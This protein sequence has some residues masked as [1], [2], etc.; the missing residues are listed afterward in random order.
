MRFI[1][2]FAGTVFTLSLLQSCIV[3]SLLPITQTTLPDQRTVRVVNRQVN[4]SEVEQF[5]LDYTNQERTKAGL[6]PLSLD[7][8]LAQIARAHS[9]DMSQR[10]FFEHDN[11]D[12]LDPT[13]RGQAAYPNVFKGIGENIFKFVVY[14]GTDQD[15]AES[16]V[17]GWMNSPGHRKNML[18]ADY[19]SL[20]VGVA[21]SGT[22]LYATQNFTR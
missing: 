8:R 1:G 6:N 10:Q 5:V 19:T 2:L 3:T 11:P 13:G 20:G 4:I 14:E 7:K 16:L 12:G 22:D 21:Q 18:T 9:T 15:L 17:E